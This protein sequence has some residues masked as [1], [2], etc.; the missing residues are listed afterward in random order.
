MTQ[1]A[2]RQPGRPKDVLLEGRRREEILDQAAKTFAEH[3][4][5]RTDVQWIADAVGVSKGTI[6]RYFASKEKLFLAA[7]ERGVIRFHE[8]VMASRKGIEDTLELIRVS[9]ISYLE[10]F[11]SN[12]QLVELFIQERAEFKGERRPIYFEHK[13]ARRAPWQVLIHELIEQGKIRPMPVDRVLDVLGDVLYGTMFTNH[14]AGRDKPFEA[15]AEN[16]LDVF[17]KGILSNEE[18]MRR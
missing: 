8:H 5:P 9:V 3:G 13:D 1:L 18:R 16:I 11:K 2:K 4:Y 17:F 12:P 15:Q 10:F 7:V 14:F 6:Y